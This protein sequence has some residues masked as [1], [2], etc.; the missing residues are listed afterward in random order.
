[1]K[2][3][4]IAL[5]VALAVSGSLSAEPFEALNAEAVKASVPTSTIKDS[6]DIWYE[7]QLKMLEVKA[8]RMS[9]RVPLVVRRQ[10]ARE[11]LDATFQHLQ[12]VYGI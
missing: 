1:M 4:N 10:Q 11:Q 2:I 8:Q 12:S 3:R 7:E 9:D 5:I 6:L